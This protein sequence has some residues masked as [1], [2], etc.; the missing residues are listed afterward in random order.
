MRYKY[1]EDEAT[2]DIAIES[3]GKDLKELFENLCF[4]VVDTIVDSTTV[5]PR[6]IR[7]VS[8]KAEDINSLL[9]ELLDEI[10]YLFDGE[11]MVF[12]SVEVVELDKEENFASIVLKGEE[13]DCSKHRLK[14]NVK[15]VTYFGMEIRKKKDR[16]VGKITLDL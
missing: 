7:Y 5:E 1:L 10:I 8:K 3:E 11:R 6:E 15:A 14:Y 4:A 13:L 2:A 16:Y 9:Y 12:H